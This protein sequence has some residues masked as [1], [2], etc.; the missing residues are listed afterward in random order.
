MMRPTE[1]Q[2]AQVNRQ[3]QRGLKDANRIV[4]VNREVTQSQKRAER[5]AFPKAERDHA[6]ARPFRGDPLNEEAQTENK[7]AG[8]ADNFP[9]IN[10]D[11]EKLGRRE[12][13]E[14]AHGEDYPR[15]WEV[16]GDFSK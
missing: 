4:P 7:G 1:V 2:I 14:G 8:E 13:F 11:V 9:R 5:A 16:H 15:R 12:E 6:F 10:R 3:R